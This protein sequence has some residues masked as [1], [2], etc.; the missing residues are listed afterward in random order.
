MKKVVIEI[1]DGYD[2][3]LGITAIGSTELGRIRAFSRSFALDEGDNI[4]I[5]RDEDG[6]LKVIQ[7]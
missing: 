5:H 6:E 1:P 2:L 4:K 3:I 7:N